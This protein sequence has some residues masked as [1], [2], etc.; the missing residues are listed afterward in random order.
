MEKKL[1]VVLVVVGLCSTVA[2]ALDPMGPPT[3]DLK[4]GQWSAGVAYSHSDMDFYRE[5]YWEE[6]GMNIDVDKVYGR[7]GFGIRDNWELFL[8]LGGAGADITREGGN[9][10]WKG[11]DTAFAVGFGAKT[12][13]YEDTDLKWGAV[14]QMSWAKFDG[15]EKRPE[16][17]YNYCRSKFEMELIEFQLAI[18]PTWTPTKGLSI[19]GGPFLH[20]IRGDHTFYLWND[21]D[22]EYEDGQK[23]D[24]EENKIFGGYVGA[25]VELDSSI[26]INVEWMCTE[27]ADAFGA[28]AIVRF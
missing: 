15:K 18:G 14:A 10:D 20:F 12:T 26:A 25:Q 5:K 22:E 27:D 8:L 11:S 3:A 19:Y 24:I 23:F 17:P 9:P 13:F 4:K 2:L 1:L 28:S 21:D 16:G 7:V 6:W